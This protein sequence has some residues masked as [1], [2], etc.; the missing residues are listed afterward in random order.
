MSNI[1]CAPFRAFNR[2]EGRPREEELEDALAARIH[3]PLWMLAR[4]YQFGEFK[5]EDAG[6][7]ILAKVA[8]NSVR[9]SNLE[10]PNGFSQVYSEN[11][12]LETQ[13]ERLFPQVD[14]KKAAKWGR[15]F[16][17]LLD[18]QGSNAPQEEG[19]TLGQYKNDLL[20]KFSFEV[21]EL[22]KGNESVG[23]EISKARQLSLQQ[24]T[25]FLRTLAGRAV[26]GL[27]LWLF[28]EGDFTKIN[29]LVLEENQ[30]PE[31]DRFVLW[32]HQA[33]LEMAASNWIQFVREELN[34]PVDPAETCWHQERLEYSF[35]AKVEEG[36][37]GQTELTAAAYF[38]GHLDWYSFD[39]SKE[40][41][42]SETEFDESLKTR[43]V[44]SLIPTEAAFAGMPNS[45]WWEMEDGAI[46]LGNLKASDTDIAKILV[47]QYA[48]QYSNDWLSIPYDIP[49]GSL[50]EVEG[51]VVRD[52]FGQNY[53]I[54]PAHQAGNDW[55][56]WNM[57]SLSVEKG[58][59]EKPDFDKRIL[60][61][62]VV[63]RTMES[64]PIEEIKLIRD[65]MANL[66]WAIESQIPDG[67]GG[68]IDG[69]ETAR[70]LQELLEKLQKE[71]SAL[72]MLALPELNLNSPEGKASTYKA[73]LK[74]QLGNTI[75]E[76]W[77]PFIPVHQKGSN[78]EIHFQRASM[79]RI[80]EFMPTHAVRPR[81][82]LLR[83]GIN[84]N[85]EQ[86]HPLFID[87]EEVPR[88]GVKLT[89]TYQR[90]RWYHGKIVTWYGRRKR[91]GRGEGS[92]GLN[93]DQVL[94]NN[95]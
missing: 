79:P 40:S 68:S 66:V 53:F 31:T 95:T 28:L 36:N 38:Q 63:A 21:P 24:A 39:V 87:E 65:E 62:P 86:L 14:L 50:A 90:T 58:E 34:I 5:G 1:Y 30:S 4:Q 51:I 6:S 57:Y 69:Y 18:E 11:I 17:Q 92:S 2:I 29:S 15:K 80:T 44:I 37:G 83:E 55:N 16:L 84:P 20:V 85:D 13:V 32:K 12:P 93:F 3:D 19:Y 25:A 94:E 33:I 74:Y 52:T 54:A 23:E 46:D 27:E 78:R 91:T 43:R 41:S 22:D 59:F 42:S 67:L 76:N 82:Q 26:N 60:L 64:E 77:I 61:P 81:T 88:S 56:D 71:P 72:S 7:A 75:S 47:T 48:M 49:S 73:M 8:V 89:G 45:R 35:K 70:N 9:I 10:F